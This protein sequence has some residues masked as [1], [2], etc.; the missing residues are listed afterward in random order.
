M[1]GLGKDVAVGIGADGGDSGVAGQTSVDAPL[2]DGGVVGLVHQ[3]DGLSD[4]AND[5][6]AVDAE[7]PQERDE[8][9]EQEDAGQ[10]V[11]N[12][13]KRG[14]D[15]LVDELDGRNIT[16]THGETEDNHATGEDDGSRN[17]A[18]ECCCNAVG[19]A[20]GH[21]DADVLLHEG[22]V[23][24]TSEHTGNHGADH[25]LASQPGLVEAGGSKSKSSVDALDACLGSGNG[26]GS[27]SG[28]NAILASC[29]YGANVVGD[30]D[31]E[32]SQRNDASGEGL[33]AVILCP[34]V[35][36]AHG[37]DHSDDL[38]R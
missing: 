24:E 13:L 19:H 3:S 28:H 34:G 17:Q 37:A 33:P 7:E 20:L 11:A 36:N 27:G 30:E 32:R 9:L 4:G 21:L 31:E 29:N 1:E 6:C 16:D 8:R 15:E 23:D 2:E 38:E 18:S 25:A 12:A 5:R 10:R 26:V 14:L 22:A 35:A